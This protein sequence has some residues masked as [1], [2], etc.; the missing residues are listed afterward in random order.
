MN[1]TQEANMRRWV[2]ALESGEY[3]QTKQMLRNKNG[4][5]CLGVWCKLDRLARWNGESYEALVGDE[6]ERLDDEDLGPLKAR[7]GISEDEEIAYI[8]ANDSGRKF[9]TIAAKVRKN[10]PEVFA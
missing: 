9:P 4:Y 3:K 8:A 10:H 1:K 5:C 6:P 2:E 7:L